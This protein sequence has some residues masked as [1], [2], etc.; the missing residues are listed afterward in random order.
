MKIADEICSSCGRVAKGD[1]FIPD[2]SFLAIGLHPEDIVKL[3]NRDQY[4]E[5]FIQAYVL[6]RGGEAHDTT[7]NETFQI[8]AFCHN[9]WHKSGVMPAA[10]CIH[11][12]RKP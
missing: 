5:S 11:G 7:A 1:E 8:V 10:L 4:M 9:C 3:R 2:E 6:V 12:R